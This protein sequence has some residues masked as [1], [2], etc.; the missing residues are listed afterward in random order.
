MKL[1]LYF[2]KGSFFLRRS[3]KETAA[4][5]NKG[6]KRGEIK[7]LQQFLPLAKKAGEE[8]SLETLLQLFLPLQKTAGE[9]VS[10]ETPAFFA[11]GKKKAEWSF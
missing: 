3:F 2:F 5:K 4:A 9:E 11:F 1:Q 7:K 8:V 10:L 6:K